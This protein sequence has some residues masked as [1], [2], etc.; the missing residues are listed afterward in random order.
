[1]SKVFLV[2]ID[3][4]YIISPAKKRIFISPWRPTWRAHL[5][6]KAWPYITSLRWIAQLILVLLSYVGLLSVEV[7]IQYLAN[8]V[9]LL[10]ENQEQK[11]MLNRNDDIN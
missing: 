3:G 8:K 11:E 4:I 9:E 7:F 5:N 6:I 2:Q 10:T 1:M